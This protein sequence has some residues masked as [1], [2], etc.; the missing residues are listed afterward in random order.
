MTCDLF[1]RTYPADYAWL[2]FLFRSLIR[3]VRDFRNLI[4]VYPYNGPAPFGAAQAREWG[5]RL[6]NAGVVDSVH[7]QPTDRIYPDDYVGQQITKLR[8]H[9]YTDAD[10]VCFLDSDFVFVRDFTPESLH[11]FRVECRPWDS[12]G[13][14][15]CWY[16]PTKILLREDPPY[17]TMAR[18]PFQFP[19]AL[20]KRC[21]EHVGGEAA[22]LGFGAHF[23]EF[24]LLG[25]FAILHEGAPAKLVELGDSTK[26]ARRDDF[27]KQ[28]WSWGGVTADVFRTMKD[29]GYAEDRP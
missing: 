27:V 28:F 5:L 22:L 16:P 21:Y 20:I 1:L 3:H 23:S 24:N 9:E 2:P 19:T 15:Q 25:N 29:L 6:G 26:E 12:V 13:K 8:C 7:D 17:E 11:P 4:I 18:H 14:A 10:E